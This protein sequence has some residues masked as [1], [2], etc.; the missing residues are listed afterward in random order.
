MISVNCPNPFS[1]FFGE[2]SERLGKQA[3]VSLGA[4][5]P[6]LPRKPNT[7]TTIDY[8][9][10]AFITTLSDPNIDSLRPLRGA[11]LGAGRGACTHCGGLGHGLDRCAGRE[12]GGDS[13]R[14]REDRL[15]PGP[16]PLR[17]LPSPP[18]TPARRRKSFTR[19]GEMP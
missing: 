19:G 16:A 3:M 15:P 2:G 4:L 1:S 13:D 8:Q 17:R 18:P 5:N 14:R 7:S 6:F 10:I 11:G 9:E 12:A